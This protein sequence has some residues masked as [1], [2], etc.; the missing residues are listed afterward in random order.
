VARLQCVRA[1]LTQ[2]FVSVHVALGASATDDAVTGRYNRYI[3]V[4]YQTL[5]TVCSM[6]QRRCLATNACQHAFIFLCIRYCCACCCSLDVD[7]IV[8][9]I[10]ELR[11]QTNNSYSGD[12]T[13]TA[14]V[15]VSTTVYSIYVLL[16][17]NKGTQVM[18]VIPT[19]QSKLRSLII[20][21]Q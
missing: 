11:A 4:T 2:R 17:C 18:C 7:S 8:Q 3:T 10:K 20:R 14:H 13:S 19:Q 5:H 12:S 21:L 9:R 16:Q 15:Q 6:A 1:T